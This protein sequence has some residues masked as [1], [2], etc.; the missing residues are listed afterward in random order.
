MMMMVLMMIVMMMTVM[1]MMVVMMF[2][3]SWNPCFHFS[4]AI[5]DCYLSVIFEFNLSIFLLFSKT[6]ENE[7]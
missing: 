2:M 4:L 5:F 7:F 6:V 3:I 1:M